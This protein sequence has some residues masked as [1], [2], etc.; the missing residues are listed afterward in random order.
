[1]IPYFAHRLTGL[2]ESF[3]EILKQRKVGIADKVSVYYKATHKDN[4]R[5]QTPQRSVYC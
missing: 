3:P 5:K 1:M 4:E 2:L